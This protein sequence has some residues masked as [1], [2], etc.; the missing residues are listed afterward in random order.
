MDFTTNKRK[1]S[2]DNNSLV[3][4]VDQVRKKQKVQEAHFADIDREVSLLKIQIREEKKLDASSQSLKKEI[5]Q[6]RSQVVQVEAKLTVKMEK[7]APASPMVSTPKSK[8]QEFNLPPTPSSCKW[9]GKSMQ[10]D[11]NEAMVIFLNRASIKEI[12]TRSGFGLKTA[13][14]IKAHRERHGKF[15][16]LMQIKNIPGMSQN[17]F[18]K[19]TF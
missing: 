6:L 10:E 17:Y 7:S 5:D 8:C 3:Q 12:A 11:Q 13:Q 14:L 19:V 4:E 16:S 15:T 2:E 9:S 18:N 1:V